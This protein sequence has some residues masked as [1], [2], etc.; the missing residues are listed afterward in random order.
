MNEEKKKAEKL[1]FHVNYLLIVLL[2]DTYLIHHHFNVYHLPVRLA[3]ESFG[4]QTTI[5]RRTVKEKK[6]NEL[7]FIKQSSF[8]ERII[9]M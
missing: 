1:Q 9:L 8:D 6:K 3:I 7:N 4:M 2:D 5:Q